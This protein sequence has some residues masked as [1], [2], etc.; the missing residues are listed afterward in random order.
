VTGAF[1]PAEIIGALDRHGVRYVLV[2]GVAARLHGSPT[3]TEDID[4]TPEQTAEN[5]TRLADALADLEARLAVP[6][7]PAGIEIPLDANTFSSPAMSF[8]TRAGV[9]D[10]VLEVLGVGGH[11]R[12]HRDAVPFEVQGVR[13]NVAALDDIIRSKEAASRPKDR[14]HLETL[15]ALRAEV[16]RRRP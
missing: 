5:L 1:D 12:L 13:I 14:A 16:A 15:R 4:I 7:K 10:V 11:A 6:D 9:V 8:T 3:L 2:G